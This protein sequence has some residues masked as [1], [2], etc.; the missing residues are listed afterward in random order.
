M[1]LLKNLGLVGDIYLEKAKAE[2]LPTE[3]NSVL[4]KALDHLTESLTI[5]KTLGEIS[6]TASNYSQIAEIR[7]RK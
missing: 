2:P 5:S 4:K 1:G 3:K 6:E 7:T